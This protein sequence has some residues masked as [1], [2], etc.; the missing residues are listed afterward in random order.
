MESI[1]EHLLWIDKT[2]SKKIAAVHYLCHLSLSVYLSLNARLLLNKWPLRVELRKRTIWR[3][4]ALYLTRIM[5]GRNALEHYSSE[6]DYKLLLWT[7][8]IQGTRQV[9]LRMLMTMRK[10]ITDTFVIYRLQS[11]M[12][13]AVFSL[14]A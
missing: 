9:I 4:V 14:V 3:N 8:M 1:L 5:L 11:S 13:I 2:D 12:K 7:S 10:I 6:T